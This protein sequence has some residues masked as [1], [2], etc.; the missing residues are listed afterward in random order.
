MFSN[1]AVAHGHPLCTRIGVRGGDV[2][3]EELAEGAAVLGWQRPGAGLVADRVAIDVQSYRGSLLTITAGWRAVVATPAHPFLI[4]WTG[5][6]AT[7][8][9]YLAWS[10]AGGFHLGACRLL[11]D[12]ERDPWCEGLAAR[13]LVDGAE[14]VWVLRTHASRADA[15]QYEDALA[16]L[17][18][19]PAGS[20][21]PHGTY[22]PG[23]IAEQYRRGLAVLNLHGRDFDLPFDPRPGLDVPYFVVH[24]AN[25]LRDFMSLPLAYGEA[26]WT[27]VAQVEV[28]SYA[29]LVHDVL[30]NRS[31]GYVANGLVLPG[32]AWV[33]LLQGSEAR[34]ASR[35]SE[36]EV[37]TNFDTREA[38]R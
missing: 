9:T 17:C 16:A 1:L 19:L 34:R 24:A 3:V 13:A 15:C 31:H 22:T 29:G 7:F 25:L 5:R 21:A 36:R 23:I 37:D 20:C 14:R 4:R 27:P 10:M 6:P 12:P 8:V 18:G 28:K 32:R 2:P 35:R 26:A 11:A 30:P 38:R 33:R